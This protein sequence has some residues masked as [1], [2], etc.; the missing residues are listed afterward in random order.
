MW[1]IM[2]VTDPRSLNR[3]NVEKEWKITHTHTPFSPYHT[4]S[5]KKDH[6]LSSLVANSPTEFFSQAGHSSTMK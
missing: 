1:D 5:Q 3:L 4:R 6:I 2:N